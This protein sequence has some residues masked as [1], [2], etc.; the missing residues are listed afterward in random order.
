M[1]TTWETV[2]FS[3]IYSIPSRNGLYKSKDFHGS[4][5]KVVNMG[6]LFGFD[7]ISAQ[8]MKRIELTDV[9]K[10]KYLI[11]D[12]DLLFARRS[13]VEEGSGKCSLVVN[14]VEPTVFE[15]SII[16]VRLDQSKVLPRF[17]YYY[18]K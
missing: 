13:V 9:E 7:F 2:P 5:C 3:N 1:N 12:G 6:E 17:Y 11:T 4:G 15:S 8:T 14:P 18:F 10:E 16:R